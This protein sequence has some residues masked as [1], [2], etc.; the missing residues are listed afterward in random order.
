MPGNEDKDDTANHMIS[1]A[2]KSTVI[3]KAVCSAFKAK[4]VDSKMIFIVTRQLSGPVRKILE[5][6]ATLWDREYMY[7]NIWT[8]PVIQ[9][10][11]DC[12]LDWI[13]KI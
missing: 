3:D 2:A 5:K 7:K 4:Q 9:Y 6:N 1:Q 13:Q 8:T 10:A 12:G 11:N